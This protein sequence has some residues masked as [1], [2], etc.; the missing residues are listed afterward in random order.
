MHAHSSLLVLLVHTTS[1]PAQFLRA[2][3]SLLQGALF[4]LA[5][6]HAIADA[7]LSFALTLFLSQPAAVVLSHLLFLYLRLLFQFPAG[8]WCA[9]VYQWLLV[10]NRWTFLP[11]PL[12][13]QSNQL[14]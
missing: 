9:P 8:G 13:H 14:L 10:A 7:A 12:L 2:A 4:L 5:T 3:Y 1:L 6:A 11:S